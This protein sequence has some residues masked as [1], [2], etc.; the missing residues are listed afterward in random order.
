MAETFDV[1]AAVLRKTGHRKQAAAYSTRAQ[2]IAE[3][4]PAFRRRFYS[5]DVS[6]WE[7]KQSK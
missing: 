4:D 6:S 7:R 5:L 1:Y 2:A 3:R